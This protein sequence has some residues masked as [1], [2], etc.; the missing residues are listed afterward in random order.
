MEYY[1][2]LR[3]KEVDALFEAILLLDNADECYRFF[4]DICTISEIHAI[5]QRLE[6]AKMLKSGITYQEI[7][8]RLGASTA[9][10]SRVNRSLTY[11]SGGYQL[12]LKRLK[13]NEKA[14]E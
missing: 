6:V 4:E 11:G 12:M 10:I 2:K 5:A 8:Q 13:E 7:A 14:E 9:T 3:S 1:S